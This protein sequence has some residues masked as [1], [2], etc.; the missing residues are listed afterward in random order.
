M[1]ARGHVGEL[2]CSAGLLAIGVFVVVDAGNIPQAQS[3]SG[4]GP[5]LFPYLVGTGLVVCGALLVWRVLAGGWRNM[6]EDQSAHADPDWRAFAM[7]SAGI[8]LQMML[9]GWAGFVLAGVALFVFVARGFAS[10]RLVRDL[11]IGAVLVTTAYLTFTRLLSLSL[12]SG[13]LP[14]L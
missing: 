7:I 3:F 14:F 10:A 2:L 8:V 13:W 4:I 1:S 5:R 12:P 11:V 6:P 9:I